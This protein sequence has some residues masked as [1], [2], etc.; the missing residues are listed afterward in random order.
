M[1]DNPNRSKQNPSGLDHSGKKKRMRFI[2]IGIIAFFVIVLIMMM[3]NM[4]RDASDLPSHATP[5][6]IQQ[7]K[8]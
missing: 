5:E 1:N 8:Q 2:A 3:L 4:D 6:Q 7:T